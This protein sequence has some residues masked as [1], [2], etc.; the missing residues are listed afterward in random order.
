[1]NKRVKIFLMLKLK[2]IGK[3]LGMLLIGVL[4]IIILSIVMF[5]MFKLVYWVCEF[6]PAF[7]EIATWVIAVIFVIILVFALVIGFTEWIKKNWRKAGRLA[8][9]RKNG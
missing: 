7:P 9:R 6:S 2:E 4:S 1:M 8:K 5:G 3:V